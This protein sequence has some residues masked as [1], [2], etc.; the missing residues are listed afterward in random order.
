[1]KTYSKTIII[2][3]LI[4]CLFFVSCEEGILDKQPLDQ[5][6]TTNFWTTAD[7]AL[8]ALAGV[9]NKTTT[10]TSADQI[11]EFDKNTDNGI[12]RKV[13]ESYFS[14]GTLNPATSEIKSLWN[15]SYREI[16]GC[17]YFLEN[18]DRVVN[19]NADKKAQM[20]LLRSGF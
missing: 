16:A 18:I 14:Y 13:N 15:G 19:I 10:W 6:S 5:L 12:D 11:C 8:L 20:R 9:Y 4:S 1:M 2:T 7:D 17:N 3:L